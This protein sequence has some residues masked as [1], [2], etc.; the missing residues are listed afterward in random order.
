MSG[1]G[2]RGA[3]Q[4]WSAM[5]SPDAGYASDEQS[6]PRSALPAVTARLSLLGDVKVR[7]EAAA[8][9]GTP[10]WGLGPS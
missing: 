9:G 6:Q 7:G 8:G 10:S 1:G 5:S 3:G 2:A 4:G